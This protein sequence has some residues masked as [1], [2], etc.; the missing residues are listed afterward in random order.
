MKQTYESCIDFVVEDDTT[1]S[2]F[3]SKAGKEAGQDRLF[4]Q[5]WG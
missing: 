1:D 3:G 5:F 4:K 2:H